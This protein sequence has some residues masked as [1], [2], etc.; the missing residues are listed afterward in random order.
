VAGQ[1][2]L[3]ALPCRGN[4]DRLESSTL[5]LTEPHAPVRPEFPP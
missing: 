2:A 3:R 4:V 1:D 5:S